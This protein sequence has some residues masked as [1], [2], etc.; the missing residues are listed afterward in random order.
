MSRRVIELSG[1]GIAEFLQGILSNDMSK[2]VE[3]RLVY[4]LLLTPQGKMIA[5]VFCHAAGT[6]R[7]FLDVPTESL[8]QV[9]QRLLLYRLRMPID[10]T[11]QEALHV[12]TSPTPGGL[13][14][15]D[16]RHPGMGFRAIAD[17]PL[18]DPDYDQRRIRLGIP[19]GGKDFLPNEGFALDWL[20]DQWSA[21]D[22]AK[23]CYVGQEV[24]ARMHYRSAPK[25][26][27]YILHPIPDGMKDGAGV[28]GDGSIPLGKITSHAE[29][30]GLALLRIA[31]VEAAKS[32]TL[33][34]GQPVQVTSTLQSR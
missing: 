15:P 3:E 32:I 24:T 33:E 28:L 1:G 13:S 22:F 21:V 17:T 11:P 10:V 20:M 9:V 25:K 26:R 16:P 5:D 6:E 4:A 12:V 7:V 14:H 30:Y 34:N 8:E 23:G 2:I 27:P 18:P 31:D 19:E 29:G